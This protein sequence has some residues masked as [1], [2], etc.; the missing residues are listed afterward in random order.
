MIFSHAAAKAALIAIMALAISVANAAAQPAPQQSAPVPSA[1]VPSANAAQPDVSNAPPA[2]QGAAVAKLVATN[3]GNLKKITPELI[4]LINADPALAAGLIEAARQHPEQAQAL[5]QLL[6]KIQAGLK[7]TNPDGANVIAA[8]VAS[9]PPEFQAAYAV[10]L[11]GGGGDGAPA[12]APGQADGGG[13]SGGGGAASSGGGSST[14]SAGAGGSSGGL[15]FGSGFGGAI[16]GSG[17]GGSG[18][19]SGNGSG[20]TPD[21]GGGSNALTFIQLVGQFLSYNELPSDSLGAAQIAALGQQLQGH[22]VNPNNLTTDQFDGLLNVGQWFFDHDI[23][24][25]SSTPDQISA[26]LT[27][28]SVTTGQV[29]PDQVSNL[30]ALTRTGPS[31]PSLGLFTAELILGGPDPDEV[32]PAQLPGRL[33]AAGINLP[34]PLSTITIEQLQ[35]LMAAAGYN[36]PLE[37]LETALSLL[38]I[39][40][41]NFKSSTPDDNGGTPGNGGGGQSNG[42]AIPRTLGE[43]ATQL[44]INNGVDPRSL[45]AEQL[46]G[47]RQWL[48][49]NGYDPNSLSTAQFAELLSN[50]QSL[51][52]LG[53]TSTWLVTLTANQIQAL[54]PGEWR[55]MAR[56]SRSR[57]QEYDRCSGGNVSDFSRPQSRPGDARSTLGSLDAGRSRVQLLGDRQVHVPVEFGRP[58]AGRGHTSSARRSSWQSRRHLARSAQHHH[59]RRIQGSYRGREH[60]I[61]GSGAKRAPRLGGHRLEYL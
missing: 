24:P 15:G 40:P 17:S 27:L 46:T 31:N 23:D 34:G 59:A 54:E 45:T 6:S 53:V 44:L 13:G 5:A 32:D 25:G 8:L 4:A 36:V 57:S 37:E 28:A 29:T 19:S 30:L 12:G 26:L 47:W 39:D 14:G 33:G 60:R 35:G 2:G 21:N 42:G 43:L 41:E 20:T 22:G 61:D 18:G 50:A 16:G 3:L 48:T 38:D 11:A 9:A 55:A 52:D 49:N 51:V 58:Y 56:G 10:A 1:P 7:T